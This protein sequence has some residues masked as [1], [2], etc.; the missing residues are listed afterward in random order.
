MKRR[1]FIKT[2]AAGTGLSGIVETSSSQSD[3]DVYFDK[4]ANAL[5]KLP[6]AFPR[7]KSNVEILILK[8]IFSP[9]E[10]WLA[11]QLT[12]TMESMEEIAQRTGLPVKDT[13]ERL[14]EMEKLRLIMGNEKTGFRL[15][16]FIVG[17][18]ESQLDSMD[19]ELSHFFEM[20]FDEDGA[21]LMEHQPALH[22]VIPSHSA[23]KK[24]LIIPYDDLREMMIAAKSFHLRDCICR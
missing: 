1:T 17:F 2:A 23:L 21:E 20:Y 15:R 16:P 4:L 13:L 6:N 7:T 19:H 18:W 5:D 22:R 10:A 24:E 9:Q 11:G 14:T 8:K 12:G 3:D